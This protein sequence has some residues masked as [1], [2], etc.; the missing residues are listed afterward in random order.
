MKAK[1][2]TILVGILI[3]AISYGFQPSENMISFG[4]TTI[5]IWGLGTF[6]GSLLLSFL[7]NIKAYE[8]ALWIS[9]GVLVGLMFKISYDM[10]FLAVSHNLLGIEVIICAFFTFPSSFAGA[11]LAPLFK[12]KTAS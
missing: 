8:I 7:L 12:K 1:I 2:L 9:L 4:N 5:Y 6:M 10:T 3:G 11:Y